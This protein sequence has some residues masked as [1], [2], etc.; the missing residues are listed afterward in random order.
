MPAH[1]VKLDPEDIPVLAAAAAG[2]VTAKQVS[3]SVGTGIKKSEA[4]VNAA[5]LSLAEHQELFREHAQRLIKAGLER[6]EETLPNA[7]CAQATLTVGVL[8][9]KIAAGANKGPSA[10]HLHLHGADRSEVLGRVLGNAGGRTDLP[11]Q[12]VAMKRAVPVPD[13]ADPAAVPARPV[14]ADHG[15]GKARSSD[16]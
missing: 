11:L 7:S 16:L 3:K 9:D 10:V 4:L 5:K 13:S 2:Q 12:G 15:Q 1:R 6:I 8:T 14:S